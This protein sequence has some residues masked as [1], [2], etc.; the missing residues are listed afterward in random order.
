MGWGDCDRFTDERVPAGSSQWR[1]RGGEGGG[2]CINLASWGVTPLRPAPAARLARGPRQQP[3]KPH[4]A[5]RRRI[6]AKTG[7]IIRMYTIRIKLSHHLTT[8]L[9]RNP[10]RVPFTVRVEIRDA[11]TDVRTRTPRHQY[12]HHHHHHHHRHQRHQG[13]QARGDTQI[14]S[15]PTQRITGWMKQTCGTWWCQ[16]AVAGNNMPSAFPCPSSERLRP[17]S[18]GGK[19]GVKDEDKFR[20]HVHKATAAV[21]IRTHQTATIKDNHRHKR[22]NVHTMV[23]RPVSVHDSLTASHRA[24]SS[25]TCCSWS[26]AL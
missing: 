5:S 13:I 24:T 1:Q 9:Q 15:P 7:G 20:R 18:S 21:P 6:R 12:H 17:C 4:T 14:V 16:D 8:H 26:S 19:V 2:C 23:L 3:K 25:T 22:R 11:C 10:L